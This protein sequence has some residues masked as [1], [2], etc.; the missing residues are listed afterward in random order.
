MLHLLVFSVDDCSMSH[1][2]GLRL[3]S[4]THNP[5]MDWATSGLILIQ[6]KR[7]RSPWRTPTHCDSTVPEHLLPYV[8][9]FCNLL[10][11]MGAGDLSY[12]DF[13]QKI[14]SL[15]GELSC[16][17][18]I[19]P[20]ITGS[21]IYCVSTLWRHLSLMNP[22]FAHSHAQTPLSFTRTWFFRCFAST[23]TSPVHSHWSHR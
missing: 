19:Q 23:R 13:S 8:P 9:I 1:W 2:L 15:T 6:S 22:T 3:Y 12:R 17:A 14:E 20:H 21:V 16:N 10:P 4:G 18:S 11:S 7:L 5:R